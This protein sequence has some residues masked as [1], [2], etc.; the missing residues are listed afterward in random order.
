MSKMFMREVR[1]N[2]TDPADK[3]AP[4]CEKISAL[5]CI[6]V[7]GWSLVSQSVGSG[8]SFTTTEKNGS[9]AS[10][11]G[12][13]FVLTASGTPW[14]ASDDGKWIIIKDNTNPLNSGVY[15][16][17]FVSTST[18]TIDFRSGATEYPLLSSNVDWWLLAEGYDVPSTAGDYIRLAPPTTTKPWEIELNVGGTSNSGFRVRLCVDG[19]WG[20]SKILTQKSWERQSV[21]VDYAYFYISAES[22][23]SYIHFWT[24]HGTF[25]TPKSNEGLISISELTAQSSGHTDEDLVCIV[26]PEATGDW[27]DIFVYREDDSVN[28]YGRVNVWVAKRNMEDTGR[29]LDWSYDT[30]SNSLSEWTGQEQNSRLGEWD[31]YNEIGVLVDPFYVNDNFERR[32]Y[33]KGTY[34]NS[35]LITQGAIDI[36]GNTRRAYHINYGI[37]L[38]WSGHT[39]QF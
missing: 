29:L 39:P 2:Q 27:N 9:S 11:S 22:D 19:N 24:Y 20:G 3:H 12:S 21:D 33:V 17:N 13:D 25:A 15:W 34:I 7:V 16:A 35:K 37:S 38:D 30:D 31:A 28:Y 23:G 5:F 36:N 8:K 6:N 10:F 1:F 14:L 26:G 4:F 18:M 32:G